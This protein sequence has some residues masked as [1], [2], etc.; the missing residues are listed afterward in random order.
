MLSKSNLKQ[1]IREIYKIYLKRHVVHAFT[2]ESIQEIFE[3]GNEVFQK[4]NP[5]ELEKLKN[6]P[7][8]K[9]PDILDDEPFSLDRTLEIYHNLTDKHT[10]ISPEL[11]KNVFEMNSKLAWKSYRK[12]YDDYILKSYQEYPGDEYMNY[13][14]AI[15]LFDQKEYAEALRCIN[16]A[17]QGND[18]SANY[19]HIKGLCL[20]QQGEMDLSRTSLYQ[21]LFLV[22]LLE[23]VPPH[24]TEDSQLYP[25][26]PI[27]FHTSADL[28]R[29][30]LRKLDDADTLF[31]SVFEPLTK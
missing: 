22:E 20:M 2:L 21:A 30:D 1:S 17:I 29:A 5:E 8:S 7:A 19:T 4:N 12:R 25:N 11:I 13:L 3:I 27:E 15:V 6:R 14:A 23:D 9:A 10:D 24:R 31:R 28:I 26:Y 16:L 18:S